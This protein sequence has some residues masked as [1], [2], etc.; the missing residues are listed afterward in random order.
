M[1]LIKIFSL[2]AL[3][4]VATMALVGA[5]S[6]SAETSTQLCK[7]HTGLTCG[8]G[9]EVA[10]HHMVLAS[11]TVGRLLGIIDVLCL[12]ILIEATPLGLGNP[13]SIHTT[14]FLFGGCGTGSAHNNCTISVQEQPLANL[15]KTGLDA[16]VLTFTSGR[17]RTQ[18][19]SAGIDCVYD[20][21]GMEFTVGGQHLTA[22]ETLALELG[23]Q[24]FCPNEG[25]VD[26]LFETLTD[27]Y[28]LE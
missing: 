3:A 17:L 4:A 18:C 26:G 11:G 22:E 2:A 21:E 14:S 16:G 10:S 9:N 24:F 28:V 8:A 27:T 15:L 19:A 20:G 1:R 23:G 13:Q 25:F 5:T 6:A 12:S 7:V